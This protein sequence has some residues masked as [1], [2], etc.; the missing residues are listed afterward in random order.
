MDYDGM[1]LYEI[2]DAS[3][4]D[5]EYNDIMDMEECDGKSIEHLFGDCHCL[6]GQ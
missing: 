1:D 6:E 3:L 2:A 5:E 4:T